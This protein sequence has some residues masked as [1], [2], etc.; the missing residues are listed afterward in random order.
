[1]PIFTM[2]KKNW[3][4]KKEGRPRNNASRS[5][6]NHRGTPG[7]SSEEQI[8]Y[9]LTTSQGVDTNVETTTISQPG[10][11]A[12]SLT[13]VNDDDFVQDTIIKTSDGGEVGTEPQESTDVPK[14]QA[15]QES[16]LTSVNND[17]DDDITITSTRSTSGI[18]PEIVDTVRTAER[19][20]NDTIKEL[21]VIGESS[22]L[23]E[24]QQELF[25]NDGT[26]S[27]VNGTTDDEPM[28]PEGT[29]RVSKEV[30]RLSINMNQP[31]G[32]NAQPRL[33]RSGQGNG[34][35]RTTDD[36]HHAT[37][38]SNDPQDAGD[39]PREQGDTGTDSGTPPSTNTHQSGDTDA[40]LGKEHDVDA[41]TDG[42]DKDEKGG[43]P[44]FLDGTSGDHDVRSYCHPTVQGFLEV[45]EKE[46]TDRT[47]YNTRL[48]PLTSVQ[49]LHPQFKGPLLES[50]YTF[51]NRFSPKGSSTAPWDDPGH[52]SIFS[53]ILDY[54]FSARF[55]RA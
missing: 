53:L 1:M 25:A 6:K 16:V 41:V 28:T 26:P 47:E 9:N 4:R 55:R 42:Q 51:F 19:A 13:D 45:V 39:T 46:Y 7:L 10:V 15:S 35:K 44:P 52:G 37:V 24:V 50:K 38:P 17:G 2:G 49:P 29:E 27:A 34:W 11:V 5:P 12:L 40:C 32:V 33:S 48:L 22:D 54:F 30:R 21:R 20:I 3:N 36:K 31:Q 18:N 8:R 43:I 14:Q 23:H